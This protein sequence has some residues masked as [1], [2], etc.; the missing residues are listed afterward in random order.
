[1]TRVLHGRAHVFGNNVDTD[2]ILPGEYLALTEPA[3]LGKHAMEGIDREFAQRVRPGDVI[4]AGT[5]FGCGSSRENAPLA[6]KG[7]GISAVIAASFARIF[8]R[9]A[10]NIGLPIFEL[11]GALEGIAAGD[12]VTIE[13]A[14]GAIRNLGSGAVFAAT[15]FSP[16]MQALIDAGGLRP[17]VEARLRS[18]V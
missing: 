6:I 14:A 12:E 5:N 1:M 9:N 7:A 4:V 18:R 8:Y 13:P 3:D 17:Y 11:P 2:V 15:P 16:F 10:I